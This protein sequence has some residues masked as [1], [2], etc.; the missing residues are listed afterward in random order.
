[1]WLKICFHSCSVKLPEVYSV[2]ST[3]IYTSC[4]SPSTL[5]ENPFHFK[6]S[7]H[8]TTATPV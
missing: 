1:M 2:D 5:F 4:D 3:S 6:V 8:E 7:H